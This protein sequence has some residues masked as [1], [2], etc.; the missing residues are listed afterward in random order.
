MNHYQNYTNN[1]I[2]PKK[3]EDFRRMIF[4]IGA[5]LVS[6]IFFFSKKFARDLHKFNLQ[7]EGLITSGILIITNIVLYTISKEIDNLYI[8][9]WGLVISFAAFCYYW[10]TIL[11]PKNK[12][13]NAVIWQEEQNWH[14]LDGWE[15]EK[16]VAKIYSDLGYDVEV[17]KGSA[18]GGV[19][20]IMSKDNKRTIVQ[21][22]HHQNPVS[23][24][25]IRALWGC[26]SDFKADEAIFIA[27]SG[28]TKGCYDFVNGK[29]NYTL[30]T[31]ED[32]MRIAAT[33]E[34]KFNDIDNK[35]TSIVND[36]NIQSLL[37]IYLTICVLIMLIFYGYDDKANIK[38][39]NKI[40]QET[41]NQNAKNKQ[42]VKNTRKLKEENTEK[43]QNNIS[44]TPKSQNNSTKPSATLQDGFN[45]YMQN[46]ERKI[47]LQWEPPK[48]VGEHHV[49]VN[50]TVDR[51][52][53]LI[54]CN[55]VKSSG[56]AIADEA[57]KKAI[58]FAAPFGKLPDEYTG[59]TIS[60]DFTFDFENKKPQ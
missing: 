53:N 38:H 55:I 26:M 57:A 27:S 54:N 52:G 44:D 11:E 37:S 41:L 7:R 12:I 6:V 36:K 56:N 49:G 13:Y 40:K 21:C 20:I 34:G 31:L 35:N 14:N 4:A 25:P 28:Y 30:L 8:F 32:I 58:A 2:D 47:Y 50:F 39:N 22:K 29:K 19:D 5:I 59:D 43:V 15:F 60:I 46:A 42:V 51:N 1:Y 48:N 10:H 17:T 18:D 3:G 16:E 23:V 9:F 24:E 33:L 45:K